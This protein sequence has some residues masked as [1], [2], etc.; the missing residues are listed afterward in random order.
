VLPDNV[1]PCR[2]LHEQFRAYGEG[3]R[4]NGAAIWRAE[5]FRST[6]GEAMTVRRSKALNAVLDRCDLEVRPGELLIGTG[7]FGRMLP[8]GAYADEA[9]KEAG[10]ELGRI[11]RRTFRT[12]ADHHAPDYPELLR[13]GFG[14]LRERVASSLARHT[15]PERRTF[16]TSV[17]VALDGA[18]RHM[19]RWAVR[20][21]ALADEHPG[22]AELLQQQAQMMDRLAEHE[23]ATFWEALQL[24]FS[25]HSIMQM[26]D[27]YAMAFGR[28]DQYMH[29]FYQADRD[30]GRLTRDEA[31]VLLEHFFAKLTAYEDVQ[32]ITVGGVRPKDGEDA[33]NDLSFLILEACER[34]G[35]PGGNVTARIHAKTPPAF[36][37]KCAEVIRSGIG[38]PAV[39][40]DAVEIPALLE[41]GYGLEEACDYGFV[42]CIEVFIPG[43]MAPW[44]DSR[45]NLLRC[46]NLALHGGV[47]NLT[48]E[49]VGPPTGEPKNWDAFYDAFHTQMRAL[50]REHIKA[51]SEE[52][53]AV[54]DRADEF[55]SP[56]MSALTADCIERGRDL[57]DGGAR[58]PA[59]HG[60]AGMG[61]GTTADALMAVKRLVYDE[62]RF[63]LAQLKGMLAANFGGYEAERQVLLRRAPKYGNNDAEVDAIAVR[64]THDFGTECLR[65]RT[66]QGGRY[67]G[68]MAANVQ[69]IPAGREVGATADGR[70]SQQPLSDASSPTFGRDRKG[71]TA[72]IHSVAKLPYHLCP[73]GNVVNIKLHPS[74]LRGESGL[75]A[76][77][78]L[79]RTAFDLGAIELQFNTVDRKLLLAAM[80]RPDEYRDLV[81]RVSGFSAHFVSLDRAVQEDVLARTEHGQP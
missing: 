5:S 77:A 34:V 26:D 65:H 81:V 75:A 62:K 9:V 64:V 69:N 29:P 53:Q 56:L 59:N 39:F 58:H 13:L 52:K 18:S 60:V 74:V 51:L 50:L 28:L 2:E 27:R 20:L 54:G 8:A 7:W 17:A 21:A 47:D 46:V 23:P 24:V 15:E 44:A 48:G 79:I 14:G 11:G 55:T 30:A 41:Q 1:L 72:V 67:W 12:H 57:N 6:R 49:A 16:L 42:G 35:R 71:P 76:L 19:R 36:L 25:V 45:F 73:G 70:F 22:H 3:R 80:E 4:L 38:Y 32:N 78:A 33:T 10:D 31:Q 43:R 68:L 63:D 37:R 66:P 61:I 40:S